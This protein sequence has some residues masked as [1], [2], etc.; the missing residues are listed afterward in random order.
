[1]T[2]TGDAEFGEAPLTQ[3]VAAAGAM[4]RQLPPRPFGP[5]ACK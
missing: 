5:N 1:M 2:R 3:T 4:A